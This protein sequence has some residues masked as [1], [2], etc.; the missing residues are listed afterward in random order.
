[1]FVANTKPSGQRT[2]P[3]TMIRCER[4]SLKSMAR[5]IGT[6]Y[7]HIFITGRRRQTFSFKLYQSIMETIIG[8]LF[9]KLDDEGEEDI[10][11]DDSIYYLA[12]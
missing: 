7:S 4:L 2:T 3:T 1:M 5:Y 8:E 9:L 6:Q 11:P 10:D 12:G